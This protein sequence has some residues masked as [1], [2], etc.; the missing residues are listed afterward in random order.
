MEFME[1][2]SLFD[3]LQSNQQLPWELRLRYPFKL[4]NKKQRRNE[5][6][7]TYDPY[8]ANQKINS[9]CTGAGI[10]FKEK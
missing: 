8:S 6:K 9:K 10:D 1:G 5:M 2:G 7:S 4:N 3:L